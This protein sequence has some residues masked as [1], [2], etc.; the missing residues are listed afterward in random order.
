MSE[1][2]VALVTGAN[3]GMGFEWCKQLAIR[4][5][6]I[7]LTARTEEKAHAAA[8]QLNRMG[9]DVYPQPLDVTSESQIKS[10]ANWVAN[11]FETLDLLVNNAGVN[12][13]TRGKLKE[14]LLQKNVNLEELDPDEVLHMMLV[15]AIAPV[16][17]AKHFKPI[18]KLAPQPKIISISS[19]L[20]SISV[21]ENGSNYSY[22][23]SKAALNMMNRALAFDL[24]PDGIIAVVVNP[25]GV[26]TDMSRGNGP[27]TTEQ[28]VNAMIREVVEKISIIDTGKFVNWGGTQHP[29]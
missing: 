8:E 24:I 17:M 14:G 6:K 2:K 16:L 23:A 9:L 7:V 3:K 18:M 13:I 19:W 22:T 10:L 27:M 12:A 1:V 11:N 4:H 28:S 26:K 29:W 21:R 20:G 25:G 15:N 5:Y